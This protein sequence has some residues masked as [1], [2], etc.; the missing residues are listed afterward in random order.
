MADSREGLTPFCCVIIILSVIVLA[1]K[2]NPVT[3]ALLDI[4]TEPN[5]TDIAFVVFEVR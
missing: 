2:S 5:F 1:S 4:L 3:D